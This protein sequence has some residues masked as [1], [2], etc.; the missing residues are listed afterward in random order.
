MESGGVTHLAFGWST[1]HH[2]HAGLVGGGGVG[3]DLDEEDSEA[4][5]S[6][7]GSSFDNGELVADAQHDAMGLSHDLGCWE[8]GGSGEGGERVD[9]DF[10]EMHPLFRS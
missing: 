3:F 4:C 5:I 1:T 7:E 9:S 8:D 10:R 6:I 2:D